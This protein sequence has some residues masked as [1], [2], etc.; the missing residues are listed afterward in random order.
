MKKL[1]ILVLTLTMAFCLAG[2]ACAEDV[3]VTVSISDGSGNAVLVQKPVTVTDADAD[4][5]LT[6]GDALA[7]AHDAYFP[8]GAAAGFAESVGMYGL[9]LDKLWG[10]DAGGAYGY[11]QNNTAANS[12]GDVVTNGAFISAF[13]YTDTVGYSDTYC[14]FDKRTATVAAGGSVTLTLT[15]AG[16]DSSWSPITFAIDDATIW[17]DGVATTYV[18][19]A[20]GKVTIPCATAGTI[21]V[22]AKSASKTLVPTSC[23]IT[24]S[25]AADVSPETGDVLPIV[26]IAALAA[27]AFVMFV[28]LQRK[29]KNA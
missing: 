13:I 19:D 15:G 20:E 25:A 21:T 6:I 8:G 18:T 2:V 11:Y 26:L 27:G 3:T 9:Q 4:G 16:Y 28:V 29:R 14:Y 23:I 12:L 17:I 7:C 10:T 22:S 5:A 1:I 24:V